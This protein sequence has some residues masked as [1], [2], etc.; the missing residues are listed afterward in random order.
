M[1]L[2]A[3]APCLFVMG[4]GLMGWGYGLGGAGAV[5]WKGDCVACW[6]GCGGVYMW[7]GGWMSRQGVGFVVGGW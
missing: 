3:M 4:D 1:H 2:P 5:G 7:W 6:I